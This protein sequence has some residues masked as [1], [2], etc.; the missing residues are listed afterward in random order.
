MKI[1]HLSCFT[2]QRAFFNYAIL[3][4]VALFFLFFFSPLLISFRRES[5][6]FLRRFTWA[7]SK[8]Y[9]HLEFYS[10][11]PLVTIFNFFHDSARRFYFYYFSVLFQLG[12][13]FVRSNVSYPVVF[14]IFFYRAPLFTCITVYYFGLAFNFKIEIVK[15]SENAPRQLSSRN[16]HSFPSRQT[17]MFISQLQTRDINYSVRFQVSS[18]SRWS[19]NYYKLFTCQLRLYINDHQIYPDA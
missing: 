3:V 16:F 4:P 6:Y 7:C 13:L 9:F 10:L 5:R 1:W 8:F 19:N 15:L 18:D 14:H 12:E 17:K 2:R 11:L